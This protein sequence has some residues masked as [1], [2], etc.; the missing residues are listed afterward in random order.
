M[1]SSA[2]Q[3][4]SSRPR[5]GRCQ[6]GHRRLLSK[7]SPPSGMR[8]EDKEDGEEERREKGAVVKETCWDHER[9]GASIADRPSGTGSERAHGTVASFS[10][11]PSAA[12]PRFHEV[13]VPVDELSETRDEMS[14]PDSRRVR[15]QS[16]PCVGYPAFSSVLGCGARIRPRYEVM[17]GPRSPP[18]MRDE[19]VD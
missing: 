1:Q 13:L 10:L 16:H 8:R 18:L 14:I 4:T 7:G 12:G 11:G 3:C 15:T 2:P 6:Y 9:H 19:G 17:E 5:S